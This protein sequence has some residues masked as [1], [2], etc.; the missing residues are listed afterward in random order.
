MLENLRNTFDANSPDAWK[1][2]LS[3]VK[4]SVDNMMEF[5]TSPEHQLLCALLTFDKLKF[6]K[7]NVLQKSYSEYLTMLDK[8]R[9]LQ[10]SLLKNPSFG[11]VPLFNYLVTMIVQNPSFENNAFL[12]SFLSANPQK[13]RLSKNF[14]KGILQK[15]SNLPIFKIFKAFIDSKLIVATEQTVKKI[16]KIIDKIE[17]TALKPQI[18]TT[19]VKGVPEVVHSGK[20]GFII[21]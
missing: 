11:D 10:K 17:S 3:V 19:V 5:V 1:E 20:G 6:A 8:S 14:L 13:P 4:K 18:V 21:D 9:A 2:M 7:D 12:V 15:S 16:D